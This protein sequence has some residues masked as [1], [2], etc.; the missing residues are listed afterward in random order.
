[1]VNIATIGD[2]KYLIDVGFGSNGPHKPIPLIQDYEFHNT[3][4][5]HGRLIYGPITQHTRAGQQLLRSRD[6]VVT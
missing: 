3:G 1:M 5:L 2:Q 6:H 4:D